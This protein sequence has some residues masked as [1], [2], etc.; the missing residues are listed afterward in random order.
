MQRVTI[1]IEGMSCGHCVKAVSSALEKL[2]GVKI[3]E[4]SIGSATVVYD[5]EITPMERIAHAVREAGY[6]ATAG[7]GR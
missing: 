1:A 2:D 7:A 6:E 5:P 4:V 3:E